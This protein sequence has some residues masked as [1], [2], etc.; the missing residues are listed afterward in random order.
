MLM[1]NTFQDADCLAESL[2]NLNGLLNKKNYFLMKL[3]HIQYSLLTNT[4]TY[5]VLPV[6]SYHEKQASTNFSDQKSI[7]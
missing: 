2:T 7:S 3:L 5:V 1:K 6:I 4:K